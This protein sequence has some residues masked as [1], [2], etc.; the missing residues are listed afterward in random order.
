MFVVLIS[1][2]LA[3]GYACSKKCVY[4]FNDFIGSLSSGTCQQL[5]GTLTSRLLK[6][7]GSFT[8]VQ[9]KYSLMTLNVKARPRFLVIYGDFNNFP[10][11]ILYGIV[12]DSDPSCLFLDIFVG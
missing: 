3:I 12:W 10:L 11:S 1:T 8:V 7:K 6:P 2:E 5:V 4:R 9:S